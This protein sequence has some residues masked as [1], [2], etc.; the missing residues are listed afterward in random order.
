MDLSDLLPITSKYQCTIVQWFHHNA[1]RIFEIPIKNSDH[2]QN[3]PSLGAVYRC[4]EI[5]FNR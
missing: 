5:T 3:Q 4:V 1:T 2:R